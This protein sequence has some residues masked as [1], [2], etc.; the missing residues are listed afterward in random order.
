MYTV[1]FPLSQLFTPTSMDIRSQ[2][3][4]WLAQ[5]R[6][7]LRSLAL[8]PETTRSKSDRGETEPGLAYLRQRALWFMR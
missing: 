3:F 7:A 2:V 1:P 6:Y 5:I 4:A 8:A